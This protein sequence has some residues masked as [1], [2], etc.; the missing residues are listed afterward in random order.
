MLLVYEKPRKH[1]FR[2]PYVYCK[3]GH[4]VSIPLRG[5]P[6]KV[7]DDVAHKIMSEAGDIIK[8]VDGPETKKPGKRRLKRTKDV[9]S[10]ETKG[11][12]S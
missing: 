10:Y 9:K 2:G 4:S 1:H 7:P 8:P 6:V 5:E 3:D 12:P 11:I